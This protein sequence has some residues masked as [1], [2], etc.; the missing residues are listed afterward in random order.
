M[1]Q[2]KQQTDPNREFVAGKPK[3]GLC[4]EVT[5]KTRGSEGK[6]PGKSRRCGLPTALRDWPRPCYSGMTLAAAAQTNSASWIAAT[7]V[8]LKFKLIP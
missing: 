1:N 6:I 7:R 5:G 4:K 8:A 2:L 3:S